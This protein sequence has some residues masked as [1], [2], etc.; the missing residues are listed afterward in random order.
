MIYT[1]LIREIKP[2]AVYFN[3][4]WSIRNTWLPV[5]IISKLFPNIKAVLA[6]RG[7]LDENSM[8]IKTFKKN[9]FLKMLNASNLKNKVIFHSTNPTETLNI[10]KR[11]ENATVVEIPNVN[12]IKP[13]EKKI[14]KI[15][16]R[17]KIF[18]LSR[19]VPIKKLDFI[20]EVLSDI[21]PNHLIEF[22]IY[23]NVED[24][25]Y[26]EHCKKKIQQVPPHV[27]I[28][29][30]GIAGMDKTA[31]IISQYHLLFLPSANENFGHAI[32]ESLLCGIPVLISDQTPW[33]GLESF[34]AGHDISLDRKDL[35][36]NAL[37]KFAEMDDITWM[38]W[39]RGAREFIQ[40]KMNKDE[41][42]KQYSDLFFNE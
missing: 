19:I 15:K 3:N 11:I 25:A 4:I 27:K 14:T 2:S 32:V 18:F 20:I 17:L 28:Q 41:I 30:R 33:I 42:K 12:F 34:K 23:G 39:S 37:V 35:F 24:E 5:R 9:A 36:L 8:Q 13:S 31:E 16:G 1:D 26:F 29:Y 40:K 22:D 38:E 7:M 21:S 6:T 10:K